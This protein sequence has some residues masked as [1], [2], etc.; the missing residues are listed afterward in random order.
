[1]RHFASECKKNER[2]KRSSPVSGK[3]SSLIYGKEKQDSKGD[4]E[5][6]SRLACLT[7]QM[8][9]EDNERLNQRKTV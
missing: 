6:H 7:P 9:K 2:P 4:D 5:A 8:S 1:M 3:N